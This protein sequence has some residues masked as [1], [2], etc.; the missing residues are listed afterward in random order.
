[1]RGG[2]TASDE[3]EGKKAQVATV[4]A[5]VEHK[6]WIIDKPVQFSCLGKR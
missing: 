4:S 2:E 6:K 3:E 5:E 1:M